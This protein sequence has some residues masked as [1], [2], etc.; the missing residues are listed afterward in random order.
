MCLASRII[1]ATISPAGR[2][3]WIRPALSPAMRHISSKLPV[4]SGVG[5]SAENL[6]RGIV[7]PLK[8][9]PSRETEQRAAEAYALVSLAFCLGPQ[10]D[11]ARAL[12]CA[13]QGLHIAEEIDHRQWMTAAH[14][15]LGTLY[16]DLFAFPQAL[17]HLERALHL[18]TEICSFHWIH[19]AR[20]HLASTYVLAGELL[21]AE[22]ILKATPAPTIPAQT[23][24]QRLLWCAHAELA[25][26][27]GNP[28]RSFQLIQ[29]LT[30][31]SAQSGETPDILRLARLHGEVLVALNQTSEAEE[32]LRHAREAA[33]QQGVPPLLW[34]I[35]LA[36]GKCYR[37]QRRYELAEESGVA[38][39]DL[40]EQLAVNL[41]EGSLRDNFLHHAHALLSLLPPPSSRRAAR[42]TYDGLTAREREIAVRIAHGQSS[43]EIADALVIS[44]RTIETHIG[45]I[46]SKLDYTART[47]IAAWAAQKGLVKKDE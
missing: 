22:R 28:S 25:L 36:L 5:S 35:H 12:E 39:R 23:L 7:C 9:G 24:G 20:G 45:N 30:I 6:G 43:R 14:C 18:A 17:Q 26:A 33:R 41:P 15:G 42:Q 32:L 21:Q 46:L 27:Q 11:Y 3:S 8:D 19:T 34:R 47:Q 29:Q 44:T 2:I 10:G 37:A 16:R 1:S 13:W 38:A 31:P 40:V 4:V